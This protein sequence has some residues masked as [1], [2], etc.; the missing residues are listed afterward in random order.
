MLGVPEAAPPDERAQEG[1][2]DRLLRLPR[3]VEQQGR[4]PAQS[5]VVRVEERRD[6]AVATVGHGH[7]RAAAD[8]DGDERSLTHTSPDAWDASKVASGTG[9]RAGAGADGAKG[10]GGVGTPHDVR[11]SRRPVSKEVS[12][13]GLDQRFDAGEDVAP[14]LD[15]PAARHLA[16]GPRRVNVTCLANGRGTGPRGCR[17]TPNV[18]GEGDPFGWPSPVSPWTKRPDM[19]IAP[20]DP[21]SHHVRMCSPQ[22][23]LG[24]P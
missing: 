10:E 22:R 2:L 1:F 11:R 13:E 24:P 7:S 16:S 15:L 5:G 4:E 14:V 9:A 20:D 18:A 3:V 23:L 6:R 19:R 17:P 12:T 8:R 21:D